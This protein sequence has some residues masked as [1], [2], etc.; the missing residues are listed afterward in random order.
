[1]SVVEKVSWERI[2]V[3]EFV[4]AEVVRVSRVDRVKQESVVV[5]GEMKW[6][7]V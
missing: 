4:G 6:L 1:M 3:Y 7:I 5:L 2:V